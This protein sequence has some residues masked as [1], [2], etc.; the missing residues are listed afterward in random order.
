MDRFASARSA[1]RATSLSSA[2]KLVKNPTG[3]LIERLDYHIPQRPTRWRCIAPAGLVPLIAAPAI[4]LVAGTAS[5][6]AKWV[7]QAQV[8]RVP[9]EGLPR[10]RM[11]RFLI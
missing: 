5:T 2:G 8:G 6:V 4:A 7:F 3:A 1:R 10:T 11:Y 9:L